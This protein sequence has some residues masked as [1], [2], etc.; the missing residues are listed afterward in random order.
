MIAEILS[1]GDELLLGDITDTN[2]SYLCRQL[3]AAGVMVSRVTAVGDDVNDICRTLKA[4]SRRA[5]ICL[6]TGGLGPT[7]DDLTAEA[8]ARAAG[9]ALALNHQALE[10]MALFF[11]ARNYELTQVNKKQAQLPRIAR[12]MENA[13]GTAPGFYMDLDSC[14]FFF[15][16]GVPLEMK[17]MFSLK[18]VP[19]II[20]MTGGKLDIHIE[21]I[22]VFGLGEST[23]AEKLLGVNERFPGVDLGFRARFPLIEVKLLTH[24][25]DMDMGPAK[26]WILT[27]LGPNVISG[28]GLTLAEQV[29][30]LL[31][32]SGQTLAVAESCTGG[33]I[34][35]MITDVAGASTYFLFSATTYANAAKMDVLGVAEQTLIDHGAVSEPTAREMADGARRTGK[36]DWAIATTGIAGPTGGTDDKPVG[37]VCIGVAGPRGVSAHRFVQDK[38]DRERNKQ[39]FAALALDMLRREMLEMS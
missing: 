6:V 2:S 26:E 31:S 38:G 39:M 9:T 23:V 27:Q 17:K 25:Q 7:Q 14:R 15:M 8:A 4:I 28:Q 34:A 13:H 32:K 37:T 10:S 33:L 20:Q 19:E 22:M 18:V 21:R 29:G 24:F 11:K 1:T 36:S 30:R 5:D 3:K 35:N 16:P 12:L